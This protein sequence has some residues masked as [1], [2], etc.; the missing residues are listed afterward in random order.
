MER[1]SATLQVETRFHGGYGVQVELRDGVKVIARKL[2][3]GGT[4]FSTENAGATQLWKV[5]TQMGYRIKEAAA[6]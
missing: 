3:E 6:V 5:L 4:E 2:P 1:Q